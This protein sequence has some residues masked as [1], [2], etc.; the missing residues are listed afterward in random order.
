MPKNPSGI[1]FL[2][3]VTTSLAFG[4]EI[5][6]LKIE[7]QELKEKVTSL[8]NRVPLIKE[9]GLGFFIGLPTGLYNEDHIYGMELGCFF[10]N[11][12]GVRADLHFLG[13]LEKKSYLLVALPSIGLLGKSPLFYNFH[14]Y[15]GV[16]LGVS[17]EL[18]RTKLGPFLHIRGFA[19]IE[20]VTTK[21]VCF[22]MEFGGGGI[23]A[24][25][26]IGYTRGTMISGGS[27]IYF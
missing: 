17:K 23:P 11:H 3:L 20:F 2:L 14:T 25:V 4:G 27:R 19:G 1:F 15:G 18:N 21:K 5:D 10:R 7:I 6:D 16:F 9:E 8:S 22:F 24:D 26:V 12:L 13:D